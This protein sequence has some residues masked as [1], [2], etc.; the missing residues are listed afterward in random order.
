MKRNTILLGSAAALT[1]A[2]GAAF[3]QEGSATVTTDLNMRMGPGPGFKIV[4]VLPADTQVDLNGCIPADGWCK[5]T[6]NGSTGWAYSPY[7]AV[8]QTPV[9]EIETIEVIEYDSSGESAAASIIGGG[10]GAAVGA[11]VGGPVGAIV[12]GVAGSTV[13][14]SAVPEETTVYVRENPVEPVILSGEPVPGVS[15]PP[16]VDFYEVPASPTYS[17]LNVNGDTVIVDSETRQIVSVL[18]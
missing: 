14:G 1:L 13:G 9:A 11:L 12:G 3:A 5:V 16:E 7:L 8:D 2:T 10:T 15:I 17:Y 6:A 18:R 4:Q